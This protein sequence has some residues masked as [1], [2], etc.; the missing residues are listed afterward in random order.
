[1][2]IG[3]LI[4]LGID[5]IVIVVFAATVLSRRRWVTHQQGAFRGAIRVTQGE[6]GGLGSKWQRGYGRW[7][8][9]ILVWTKGP[10]L[11]RNELVPADGLISQRPAHP[12]EVKRLG[13]NPIVLQI[14]AGTA[15]VGIAATG[16]AGELLFG[17]YA[18][19]AS[20][21]PSPKETSSGTIDQQG[22]TLSALISDPPTALPSCRVIFGIRVAAVIT[23]NWHGCHRV[24]GFTQG[25]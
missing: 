10:L 9:D 19:A 16:D 2:L 17:P 15:T 20:S 7:V 21:N 11:F 14:G 1:M 6:I 12:D 8:R 3:L 5:L 25:R 24:R 4:V 23:E 13:G 18:T 22:F